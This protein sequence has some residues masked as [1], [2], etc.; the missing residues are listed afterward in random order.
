MGRFGAPEPESIVLGLFKRFDLLLEAFTFHDCLSGAFPAV[1]T[2]SDPLNDERDHRTENGPP[3]DRLAC[4]DAHCSQSTT[5][6][7]KIFIAGNASAPTRQTL[8]RHSRSGRQPATPS[9]GQQSLRIARK[10][11]S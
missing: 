1:L 6:P 10:T 2:L 5:R 8:A 9:A 4:A 7:T 3:R 11:V